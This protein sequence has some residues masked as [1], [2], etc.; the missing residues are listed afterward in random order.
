MAR[1]RIEAAVRLYFAAG[2]FVL[3]DPPG[4]QR[5]PGNETHLNAFSTTATRR[6]PWIAAR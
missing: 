2:D 5:S 3:V 4:L 6:M 1:N